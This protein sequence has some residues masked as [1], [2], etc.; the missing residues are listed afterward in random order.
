MPE[1][2]LQVPRRLVGILFLASIV[3]VAAGCATQPAAASSGAPGFFAGFLHGFIALFT[4][5]AS[6][7]TD[8][9]IYAFPNAGR[10]YDLGYLL[11]VMSFFGG[12]G[13]SSRR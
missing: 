12:S 3:L 13:A 11:G 10:W 2:S 4:F 6:W 8:V 9:R 7:F 5:I 1:H